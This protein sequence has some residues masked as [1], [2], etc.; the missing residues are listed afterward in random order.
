M[1]AAVAL[2][3]LL[4]FLA[5]GAPVGFAM[6]I[7]GAVGLFLIGGWDA[8]LIVLSSTPRST[9]SVFE[10]LTVPMFLL[11][12]E[13]VLRSGIADDLFAAAAAWFGRVR[14]G[15]G[16][17]TAFAGA[18]FG[19]ICGS[20][21]AAAATLSSASM[22][23]MLKQGYHPDMAGGAVAISGTLSMLVPPS[24]AMVIYGLLADVSIAKMLVAGVV[25]GI[26]VASAIALTAYVLAVFNPA[27][28]PLAE[29]TSL[30]E[31][32]RLLRKIGPMLVLLMTVTGAIYTGIATPTETA[33]LG[34]FIAG[35]LYFLREK[36]SARDVYDVLARAA[37][38]SCMI[39]LILL[40]AHVFATFFALTQI[41][42][43]VV[44][45]VGAMDVSTMT[46]LVALVL[47]YIVLGCFMDQMA[48]LVLTVPVVVPLLTS[49]HVDLVWF[50]V[51]LIVTAELGMV[52]PPFGL[53]VFVV[54]KYSGVPAGTIFRGT[55][56]HVIAHLIVIAIFLAFPAL[57]MW[58]P[59]Q[60]I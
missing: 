32:F 46:I 21:T 23:A 35:I 31:K 59:N 53:N 39:G 37:R 48:I 44:A 45:W 7:S 29:R 52:T 18:G 8:A 19:A 13:F 56:P 60:V 42:Q 26:V 16:I 41:S 49:M 2:F 57:V 22:P 28:A 1:I 10:F 36:R 3:A 14:G 47:I 25:P 9:A 11:M 51:I 17:A 30:A 12:A 58:L 38:S 24:I 4:F 5:V 34:A 43:G 40:G 20:S 54:S 27:S 55:I 33:A 50:G 6:L 15:L